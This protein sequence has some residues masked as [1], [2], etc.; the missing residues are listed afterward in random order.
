M[1]HSIQ[2][3]QGDHSW[4][5]IRQE[6]IQ[7]VC[8]WIHHRQAFLSGTGGTTSSDNSQRRALFSR[9]L[10]GVW[11]PQDGSMCFKQLHARSWA[12]RRAKSLGLGWV[13]SHKTKG[14]RCCQRKYQGN[15]TPA[16]IGLPTNEAG[17]GDAHKLEWVSEQSHKQI[18]DL[19]T[20]IHPLL[21]PLSQLPV[22]CAELISFFSFSPD[23]F[24]P[25]SWMMLTST[26]I[27]RLYR[28]GCI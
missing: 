25:L 6:R 15:H 7:T 18:Q 16:E 1:S 21:H 12:D 27:Y 5:Y 9:N 14:A 24:Q 26:S 2:C 3:S 10:C 13:G 19:T 23:C 22:S 11:I 8:G 20:S 17:T 28:L 4:E